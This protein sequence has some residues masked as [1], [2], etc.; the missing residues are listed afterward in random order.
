LISAPADLFSEH[1]S[2][3]VDQESFSEPLPSQTAKMGLLAA[4]TVCGIAAVIAIAIVLAHPNKQKSIGLVPPAPQPGTGFGPMPP[5]K[6]DGDVMNCGD[7]NSS[8]ELYIAYQDN[9]VG[10]DMKYLN[11]RVQFTFRPWA[12]DKDPSGAWCAWANIFGLSDDNTRGKH[13]KCYFRADHALAL[14]QFRRG[15]VMTIRGT[16]AGKT[17][18]ISSYYAPVFK[19]GTKGYAKSSPVIT[20]KDCQLVGKPADAKHDG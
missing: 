8:N 7:M 11:K 19:D 9:E 12:I 13:F 1:E 3:G 2:V 4:I 16:C 10:A 15:Q 17:G 20:F 18:M 5:Q 6:P 14:A